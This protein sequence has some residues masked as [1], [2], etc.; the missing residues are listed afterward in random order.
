MHLARALAVA[1]LC[2]SAAPHAQL[3]CAERPAVQGVAPTRLG[4]PC[5]LRSSGRC[6]ARSARAPQAMA[7]AV[8]VRTAS[9]SG[10]AAC[11]YC[12]LALHV[13]TCG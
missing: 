10:A 4:H 3:R 8:V 1:Q 13:V 6:G 2:A 7:A 12:G 9:L 11:V 5:R